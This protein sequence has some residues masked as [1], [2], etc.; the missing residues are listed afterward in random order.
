MASPMEMGYAL[1]MDSTVSATVDPSSPNLP[2]LRV[3]R[4]IGCEGVEARSSTSPKGEQ[5][6]EKAND[7]Y[8]LLNKWIE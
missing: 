2:M 6:L 3:L 5:L 1:T 7:L 4:A 8:C